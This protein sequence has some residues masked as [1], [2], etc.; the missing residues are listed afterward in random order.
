M[1]PQKSELCNNARLHG[2]KGGA[3]S[4][5]FYSQASV[6]SFSVSFVFLSFRRKDV[7]GFTGAFF[8]FL[9]LCRKEELAA[10]TGGLFQF[11][12]IRIRYFGFCKTRKF[13]R[14]S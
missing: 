7:A 12:R 11:L 10:L 13:R 1:N 4:S 2:S 9:H 3:R 5:Y 8:P 6:D 14:R